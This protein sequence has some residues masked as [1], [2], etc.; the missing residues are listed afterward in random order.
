M[1]VGSSKRGKL[2]GGTKQPPGRKR[3]AAGD[4]D[5]T[6][7]ALTTVAAVG[8][9]PAQAVAIAHDAGVAG[10]DEAALAV[11]AASA[12]HAVAIAHAAMAAVQMVPAVP[13]E[14]DPAPGEQRQVAAD[15]TVD[16]DEVPVL[17]AEAVLV[18][19]VE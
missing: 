16:E 3:A 1:A 2:H 18:E 4:D 11:L 13:F 7:A 8:T 15:A 6:A 10:T 5:A 19:A 14:E 9:S 17:G 12:T